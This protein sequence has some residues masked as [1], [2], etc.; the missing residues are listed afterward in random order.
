MVGPRKP[1][2][3]L[4]G[5]VCA[6]LYLAAGAAPASAQALSPFVCTGEAFIIQESDADLF[7]VDQTVTPFEFIAV[8]GAQNLGFEI[9]NL[10]FNRADGF[11]YGWHRT[12]PTAD[13]E[14]EVVTID[15]VGTVT[16]LGTGGL[17][18]PLDDSTT[19]RFNAGDVSP[20]GMLMYLNQNGAGPIYTLN[21]PALTLADS[22]T[23]SGGTGRV[24]DWTAHP[25]DGM[26][27]GGD[28]GDG[29]LAI[30][31]PTDGTR[32][33]VAVAG[34]AVISATCDSAALPTSTGFG[35]AWFNAAGRLF[36]FLNND[37]GGMG[38]IFA[39]DD[40]SGS[41]QIVRTQS[42]PS[43][44]FN[45][46]AACIQNV[47]GGAK[48]MTVIDASLPATVVID[49]VIE[50]FS[51]TETLTVLSARDDLTTT[52]GVHGVDWTFTSISSVP[53]GFAN[54]G[55]DGH[56]D[57]ELVNQAPTQSLA[58]GEIATLTVTIELLT[59][60]AADINGEFCNQVLLTGTTPSG[61]VVG[62]LS[63]SGDDPDPDMDG[64]PVENERTCIAVPA[65]EL[66]KT[67]ALDLGGDGVANPGDVI[68]Y[69]FEVTNT[70]GV[71]LTDVLISDPLVSPITC[72]SG[73]P[74]P[75]LG[76]GESETCTGS[77][78]I[79]QAD[80]DAGIVC[81]TATADSNETPPTTDDHCEPIPQDPGLVLVKTGALDDGGDGV[82]PGDVITYTF[83]VTNTGNV[84]LTDVL[85][86]DPLVSPITCPSGNPIPTLAPGESETCTG[87]YVIT[88]ADID[89]GERCNTA[90][91]SG[92]DPTGA[93]VSDDDEHCE[94]LGTNPALDL[95]KTGA[96]DLGGDGEANPGDVITY[97]FEV[98]NIGNV[99]LT[100]VLVSDPLVSPITCP[101]GNPIPTLA[102]GESETC[103]GD[104]MITQADIDAG[105]RCNTATASGQDPTGAPV[106][107]DDEHCEPIPQPPPEGPPA[108]PTLSSWSLAGFALLLLG[109][110]FLAL[111]RRL[112]GAAS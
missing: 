66:V 35:G 36:L 53:A 56:T 76:L 9:N 47:I 63:M 112:P 32:M 81:N 52:F 70:G 97:N 26:L 87:S 86:S 28:D 3:M 85:V 11:L 102:P 21:L 31:D 92:Q 4:A 94:P 34:C 105:E 110:G 19:D 77:Y 67:G 104:Y 98:T 48:E 55:F 57:I 108:I 79:T 27:Y 12:S 41:P 13:P 25:T 99:T 29:E 106:S 8:A 30:L 84:T 65:M 14:Q 83:E 39:I 22:E 61:L 95:V 17:P 91:A 6:A 46:A 78:V 93:P 60:D 45:D 89:A 69:T 59:L 50:N 103:T 24:A 20:D 71:V 75:S 101:G 7:V 109:L 100:D 40:P 2:P 38:K 107:D 82:D 88:Q 37:G 73:N 51:A 54:P 15:S 72:P 64:N 23:I 62:D 90:T 18:P 43:S 68:N 58:P 80:I 5:A 96:L 16:G 1:F 10:G 111:R 33:D 42:G 44:Q 74:I 49:Y